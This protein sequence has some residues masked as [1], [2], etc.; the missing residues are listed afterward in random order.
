MAMTPRMLRLASGLALLV[1]AVSEAPNHGW[2]SGWTISRLVVAVVLLIAFL[3]IESR[4]KDP[5]IEFAR[6]ANARQS[7]SP[8]HADEMLAWSQPLF[9]DETAE[10]RLV[11]ERPA[12]RDRVGVDVG[13]QRLE[14]TRSAVQCAVDVCAVHSL[15]FPDI[16]FGAIGIETD[17]HASLFH[18]VER[19]F[20]GAAE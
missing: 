8:G 10:L 13:R 4:A 6:A 16:E 9:G 18:D 12:E 7:R 17:G 15:R 2:G 14:P 11:L 20:G 19:R 3:V 1:Y 5:L